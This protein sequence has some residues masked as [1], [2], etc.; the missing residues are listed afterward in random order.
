M[1]SSLIPTR[2]I[3]WRERRRALQEIRAIAEEEKWA[4]ALNDANPVNLAKIALSLN[5]RTD[6]LHHWRDAMNRFP[7]FAKT[8]HDSLGVMLGLEL[9]DEAETIMHEGMRRAPGDQ[10]YAGGYAEVAERRGDM[11]EALRRWQFV[12]KRFPSWWKGYVHNAICLRRTGDLDQSDALLVRAVGLFHDMVP[13]WVEWGRAAD[14][15]HDWTESLRRWEA[16]SQR[17][18]NHAVGH[19]GIARALEE[20]GRLDE[21]EERFTS[22]RMRFPLAV[23]IY[24]AL[25]RIA[26]SRG[27]KMEAVRRWTDTKRR[28]PLM[29]FG[30][31]GEI[32]LLRELRR[33]SDAEVVALEAI[34]RFPTDQWPIVEYA[35]LA[36]DRQDW[37]QAV[38]RWAVVRSAWP[39][40][41]DGYLRAAEALSMLGREAEALA[42]RAEIATRGHGD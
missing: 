26:Y 17:F 20:L 34:D 1:W 35:T 28:F 32:R 22:A 30:Y 36:S 12:Q 27:D 40:R 2:F 4:L 39:G 13:V 10:F 15:R 31:E 19:G 11:S 8:S 41:G 33:Y 3:A 23:E 25:A 16:V 24:I 5:D 7:A 37:P 18:D 29:P 9:F 6:A 14:C 38:E 21:A 42:L